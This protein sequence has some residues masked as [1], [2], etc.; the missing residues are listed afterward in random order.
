MGST[1]AKELADVIAG[2]S[3]LLKARRFKPPCLREEKVRLF[4]MEQL[5]KFAESVKAEH[6]INLQST[7]IYQNRQV[8]MLRFTTNSLTIEA[9]GALV[10]DASAEKPLWC[11]EEVNSRGKR[12]QS[13][14]TG[15]EC[16]T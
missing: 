6:S 11:D 2:L 10:L 13:T 9:E 5:Q 12:D 4:F 14:E 15:A 8:N 1:T 7:G 3:D 16:T